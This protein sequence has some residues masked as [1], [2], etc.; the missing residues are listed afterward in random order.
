MLQNLPFVTSRLRFMKI[1][2]IL[3]VEDEPLAAL[4]LEMMIT[5]LVQANIVIEA[6]V[7]GT[8]KVLHE[9]LDFAFLDIDVTNGKT[10]EIANIL[11]RKQVPFVFVSGSCQA[12]LPFEL[13]SAPFIP[14]PFS[15]AQI[16]RALQAVAGSL[17]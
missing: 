5:D 17:P 9:D 13:H 2:H 1:L 14:K 8:K 12:E 6:S 11:E 15:A 10:F 16:E 3:I 4:D 7:A